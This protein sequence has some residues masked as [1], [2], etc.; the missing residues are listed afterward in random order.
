MEKE[1][2]SKMKVRVVK[3]HM[4][5]RIETMINLITSIDSDNS[6]VSSD[7]QYVADL[8]TRLVALKKELEREQ[9]V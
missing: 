7:L 8:K 4:I 6:L 2:Q 3:R 5:A 1:Y 9:N